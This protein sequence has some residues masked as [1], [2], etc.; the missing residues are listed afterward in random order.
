MNTKIYALLCILL[1][2]SATVVTGDQ[3]QQKK[4]L[5]NKILWIKVGTLYCEKSSSP[6]IIE[7]INLHSP[8]D[9]DEEIMMDVVSCNKEQHPEDCKNWTLFVQKK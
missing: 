9:Q 3:T 8:A 7:F 5:S 1:C 4:S 6:K 2:T